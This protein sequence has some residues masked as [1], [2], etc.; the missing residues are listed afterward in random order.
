MIIYTVNSCEKQKFSAEEKCM[1]QKGRTVRIIKKN[2]I[3]KHKNGKVKNNDTSDQMSI[4]ISPQ[5]IKPIE[6][7]NVYQMIYH[8]Q[9]DT[10]D[11]GVI[12]KIFTFVLINKDKI[13]TLDSNFTKLSEDDK[14][15]LLS[16]VD[17]LWLISIL[18]QFVKNKSV[19]FNQKSI[20]SVND[21]LKFSNTNIDSKEFVY[22]MKLINDLSSKDISNFDIL[23][24]ESELSALC[25][26]YK[27]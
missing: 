6:K 16:N 12:G 5:K 26:L 7:S 18:G 1:A 14:N 20:M 21:V 10:T 13:L 22:I 4:E 15:Q 27:K 25:E 11:Y 3:N 8:K 2:S 19:I 17:G 9:E 23:D 24:F